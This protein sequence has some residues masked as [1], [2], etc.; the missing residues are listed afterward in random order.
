MT[1]PAT[2]ARP[3]VLELEAAADASSSED[4]ALEVRARNRARLLVAVVAS[5][6][7][8]LVDR[9]RGQIRA[10]LLD[11]VDERQAPALRPRVADVLAL[12]DELVAELR[13]ALE[14][15]R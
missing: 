12:V 7:G 5:P 3:G 15:P 2:A 10:A 6:V 14:V 1:P 9:H 13:A 8:A 11:L 4:R